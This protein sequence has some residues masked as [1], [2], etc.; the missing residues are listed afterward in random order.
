MTFGDF[1]QFWCIAS[2]L[3]NFTTRKSDLFTLPT[4][5]CGDFLLLV[6]W[7]VWTKFNFSSYF[8]PFVATSETAEVMIIYTETEQIGRKNSEH[9]NFNKWSIK[10]AFWF[11]ISGWGLVWIVFGISV[12]SKMAS[13]CRGLWDAWA[14]GLKHENE[15]GAHCLY[16]ELSWRGRHY[17]RAD[18]VVDN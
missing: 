8:L 11:E 9:R 12:A 5:Q 13:W 4:I 14:G 7:K 3:E 2:S 10:L 18:A 1:F 17:N 16:T 6:M 15:I